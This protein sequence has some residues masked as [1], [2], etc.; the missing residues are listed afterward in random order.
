MLYQSASSALDWKSSPIQLE[1]GLP[2]R[3]RDRG[4]NRGG[5]DQLY[6]TPGIEGDLWIAAFDGLYHASSS[7]VTFQKLGGVQEIWGF[8]FGKAPPNS[9]YPALYLV[10]TVGGVRGVFRSDDA[11]NS[12]ARI[13]DDAHQWGLILQVTGDPRVYGRVYVGTH[14]RG[15]FYGD[16]KR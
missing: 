15:V 1:G 4:D 16:P 13:N 3:G 12:W 10:G 2:V 8:G 14:G 11:G 6:L 7:A 5:Q 9:T